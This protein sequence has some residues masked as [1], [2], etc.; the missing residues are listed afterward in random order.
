MDADT[1]LLLSLAAVTTAAAVTTVAAV[2]Y[3]ALGLSALPRPSGAVTHCAWLSTGGHGFPIA[4]RATFSGQEPRGWVAERFAREVG[5]R[6]G[7]RGGAGRPIGGCTY[8]NGSSPAGS[9]SRGRPFSARA[10][11]SKEREN[12]PFSLSTKQNGPVFQNRKTNAVFLF[13]FS[14]A[15]VLLAAGASPGAAPCNTPP[16]HLLPP[17][18]P[19]A[20]RAGWRGQIKSCRPAR[21][22]LYHCAGQKAQRHGLVS[23][24][25]VLLAG[26]TMIS[27]S[28]RARGL[29]GRRADRESESGKHEEVPSD[30]AEPG[31]KAAMP[32]T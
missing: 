6:E 25:F 29:Q 7:R 31:K 2:T 24:S 9:R 27:R 8:A 11:G 28:Q 22:K 1:L 21:R 20:G 14:S 30:S 19:K 23:K 26:K 3:G 4:K 18:N 12:S 17:F 16:L 10:G 13:C 5:A 15:M 32:S